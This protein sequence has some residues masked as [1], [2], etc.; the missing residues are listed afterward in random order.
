MIINIHSAKCIGIDAVAVTVEVDIRL[1]IG[2]HLVGLADAAVKESLLRTTTA[3]QTLGF[4]IPGKKIVINLAPADMHK[5]GS[6]YDLPIAVGIIAASGQ[7]LLPM[8]DRFIIMGELGL[9]GTVREIPGGLPIAELASRGGYRGCI[10]PAESAAEASEYS[11]AEIYGVHTLDDVI[12]ILSGEEDC[13]G[14]IVRQDRGYSPDVQEDIDVMDF[15]DI[16]GQEG[17]KRGLEIAAAGG[18]NAL[19]IGP[20]G[21]GKSSLAKATANILPPLCIDEALQTSKI[22]S[23]AGKGGQMQRLVRRRPFRTPHYSTSVAALIGG[24]S[25]CIMPGEISL[26]HNGVLFLDEFCEMPKK[27]IEALRAP[28]EDRKA[29]ISRLKTKVEYPASF[30]L[31]AATNPCPCGY[32]GEGAKCICTPA[33]RSAYLS[34][35][36]GP[37]MDRIDIHLWIKPVEASK[38]VR[39]QKEEPSA[40]MARRVIMARKIQDMRFK[41][42]GIHTNSEMP[43]TLVE[44]FCSIDAGC[45]A[46]L[47]KII[48]RMGL[49]ARACNR[50]LKLA[51]TIADLEAVSAS[52]STGLPP[53]EVPI[54]GSHLAEAAGY[55]LLDKQDLF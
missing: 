12:R 13:S 16:M 41:G 32:F 22:Y 7:C 42:Y 9:D 26:A 29:V 6:G 17:A 5:K 3:L 46:F 15:A 54:S 20:P 2:I 35:L 45:Q 8:A 4:R 43:G 28:L 14:L 49:S 25:D 31:I 40:E 21:S 27:A 38:I 34:R 10:L 48:D 55:R 44:K 23:V 52:I 47:E 53:R 37:I 51:R 24:G 18:H 30:M 33:K 19:L 50:I 36:S 1:G 39:K 11:G